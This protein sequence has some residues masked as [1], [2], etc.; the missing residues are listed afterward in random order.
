MNNLEQEKYQFEDNDRNRLPK[1]SYNKRIAY[2]IFCIIIFIIIIYGILNGEIILPGRRGRNTYFKEYSLYTLI[3]SGL[4]WIYHFVIQLIADKTDND[5]RN[6]DYFKQ[7]YNTRIIAIILL[8]IAFIISFI[9]Y[10]SIGNS[11][12]IDS[13][14]KKETKIYY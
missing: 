8:I 14:Y 10:D 6:N 2:I 12:I 9:M 11:K 3:S 5:K 7:A 1:L 13:K 4:I